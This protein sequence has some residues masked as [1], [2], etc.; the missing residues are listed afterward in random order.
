MKKEKRNILVGL[1]IGI[2]KTRA[3][4]VDFSYNQPKIIASIE[5]PSKVIAKKGM[6]ND[7]SQCSL[8]VSNILAELKREIKLDFKK[9]RTNLNSNS[10]Q[11]RN[12]RGK[13]GVSRADQEITEADLNKALENAEKINFDLNRT[14]LQTIVLEYFI[15][16]IGGIKNPVG[17]NGYSLEVDVLVV[18]CFKPL[19]KNI[20]KCIEEAGNYKVSQIV[21]NPL[22]P[23]CSVLSKNQKEIGALLLDLGASTTNMLVVE[24]DKIVTMKTFS[25]GG[26]HITKDIALSLK[27]PIE[28]AEK[29]KI[30]FGVAKS[31]LIPKKE[32]INLNEIDKNFQGEFDRK[33][34]AKIIEARLEDIFELVNKELERVNRKAG[35]PG[36]V[37]LVGGGAKMP[38]MPE[39]AKDKLK[40][41]SQIG[42][43]VNFS[44]EPLWEDEERKILEDPAWVNAVGLVLFP[45]NGS[46]ED[47]DTIL[48]ENNDSIISKIINFFK[49]YIPLA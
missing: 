33:Y 48:Q 22:L 38:F 47:R 49:G 9:V 40:L 25:I 11:L 16:N 30:H 6:I 41:T 18:D 12:S 5:K 14:K 46:E 31:S 34:L 19:V 17:M 7:V 15:D 20:T 13:T 27:I 36:G 45:C 37:V 3:L 23:L 8:L 44:S 26:Y 21:Y 43:S 2:S 39:I 10:V 42:F 32:K 4:V 24:D 29:V 1:E 35:L 28:V